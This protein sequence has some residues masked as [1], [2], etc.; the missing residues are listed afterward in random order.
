MF[1]KNRQRFMTAY[2]QETEGPY[3]YLFVGN[4]P[5]TPGNKQVLSDIFGSCRV[6]PC[7][8]KSS[9][10]EETGLPRNLA[11]TAS[12]ASQYSRRQ[13]RLFDL[14][15]SDAS[16]PAVPNFTQDAP[17]LKTLPEGFGL[18]EMY[19]SPRNK[20]DPCIPTVLYAGEN[21]GL[22]K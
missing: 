21:Y 7:V 17:F 6:Y 4:Q 1:D 10:P 19:T 11:E 13:H 5:A 9:K 8:N 12:S 15:W 2:Y 20:F 16:W 14:V 22:S 18:V 3:G